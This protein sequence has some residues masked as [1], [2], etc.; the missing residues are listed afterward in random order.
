MR[1]APR[2]AVCALALAL[3]AWGLAALDYPR[4]GELANDDPVFM[5]YSDDVAL[6]RQALAS[7]K[8]G[9][10]LPIRLYSY[11]P[12]RGDTLLT[13]AARC[14]V[15]YDAIASLNRIASLLDGLPNRA[16]LLPTLPGLYLPDSS[17]NDFER[18]LLSSFD[19]D[20]PSIVSFQIHDPAA[21]S[22]HCVPDSTFDGTVRAFFL[23]PSFR[24]PLPAAVKTSSFGMRK[25]PVTGNLV[26]HKGIDL[27]AA[28]GTPV[29]ACADGT[30]TQTGSDP[31]Y[32]NY[33][34]IRHASSRESLYGHL[35]SIKIGLRQE[36]KSGT[37][38]GTVGSTGQSTGPHLHFE[39]HENGVPKNPSGFIKGS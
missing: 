14:S 30:V 31:V 36:V 27:A 7:R 2:R 12:A 34:I 10:V 8:T 15:P 16:I 33:I 38:I 26:F 13:V 3:G 28:R 6:A 19:P 11:V 25:N 39:I 29:Y 21:R 5:Q 32:G 18:L 35:D 22:V 20:D 9:D 1:R 24:F 4:I 23:T 17:A 37:I